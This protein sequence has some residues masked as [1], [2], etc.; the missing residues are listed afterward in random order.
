MASKLEELA[1][2]KRNE[3][4]GV[5]TFNESNEYDDRSSFSKS[6]DLTPTH[7]K[8]TGDNDFSQS[9]ENQAGGSSIDR[10]QRNMLTGVNKFNINNEYTTPTTE[11]NVGQVIF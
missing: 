4:L 7:G 2:I 6:D 3:L 8:G 9:A 11:G 1:I 5:N 10:A